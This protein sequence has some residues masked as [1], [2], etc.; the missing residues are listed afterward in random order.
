M[1]A[2]LARRGNLPGELTSFVGRRVELA[3]AKRLLEESR[4]VT[5][6]GAGGVGKTRLALR[7]A[8]QLERAF[9]DGVWVVDLA[10]VADSGLVAARVA[11]ALG[12]RDE[13]NRWSMSVLAE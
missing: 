5:L 7:L 1:T 11:S 9:D 10:T 12:M 3:T 8:S 4:L 2:S 6:T 13:S